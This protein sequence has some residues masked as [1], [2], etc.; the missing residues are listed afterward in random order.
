LLAS[1]I[2]LSN[3]WRR[4]PSIEDMPAGISADGRVA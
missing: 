2:V 1:G 3:W 4:V